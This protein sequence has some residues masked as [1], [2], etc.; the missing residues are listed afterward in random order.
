MLF[1]GQNGRKCRKWVSAK[2]LFSLTFSAKFRPF[3]GQ[4]YAF[5]SR[6][7]LT[8]FYHQK[9]L[10]C[11][12]HFWPILHIFGQGNPFSANFAYFG[13]KMRFLPFFCC[14]I[15]VE[16]SLRASVARKGLRYEKDPNI[17][18]IFKN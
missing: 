4:K 16:I 2:S 14:K 15:Q 17:F 3:L 11:S 18:E 8:L 12:G 9:N 6:V 13:S 5:L 1:F 10:G 7:L